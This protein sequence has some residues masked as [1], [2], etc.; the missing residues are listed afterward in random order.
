MSAMILSGKE[1]AASIKEEC[2]ATAE[3]LRAKGIVPKLGI[4]RVGAKDNDLAY[5]RGAT[6][7]MNSCSVDVQ[8]FE[9]PEDVTQEDFDKK[10]QEINDDPSV[11]GILMFLP[12]P[13]HLD[14]KRARNMLKPEKDIDGATT[15]SQAGVYAGKDLGF[16]PCTAQASMEILKYYNVDLKGKKAAVIGRSLVIGRPV[17]MMLMNANATVTI[18]H[19]KTV[20]VPSI[21][22]EADVVIAASGQMESVG[23]EYLS[24]DQT[25]IDVGISWNDAQGKLCG[26]VDFDKAE[27]IVGA[28]TPVPGGVGSVTSAVLCKHVIKA[29]KAQNGIA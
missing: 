16:P 3:E 23:P 13:K 18:C 1:V 27:P 5:E 6:K 9:L 19:T 2:K 22:R 14:E 10:L 21:T 12:L 24:A 11:N 15:G 17:A 20:D 26:D 28:I 4:L 8:V 29:C 25:V 7:T